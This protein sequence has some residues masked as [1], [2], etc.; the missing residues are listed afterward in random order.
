MPYSIQTKDGIMLDNI[1]DDV[2]PDSDELKKRVAQIRAQRLPDSV[3]PAPIDPQATDVVTPPAGKRRVK[4]LIDLPGQILSKL[5]KDVEEM[6]SR[7][8]ENLTP[9][10]RAN[11]TAMAFPQKFAESLG[12]YAGQAPGVV[13]R[14]APAIMGQR[15][16]EATRIPGASRLGGAAGGLGGELVA[17]MMEGQAPR[18]GTLARAA[19]LGATQ[20]RSLVGAGPNAVATAAALNVANTVGSGAVES[21]INE[22]ELPE[23]MKEQAT[24]ALLA[25]GG[26]RLLDAGAAARAARIRQ[27]SEA[28]VLEGMRGLKEAGVPVSTV[29]KVLPTKVEEAVNKLGRKFIGVPEDFVL[30]P[31]NV[32][33]YIKSLYGVYDEIGKAVPG[34]QKIVSDLKSAR[35]EA[36][37]AWKQYSSSERS[38]AP[39]AAKLEKARGLDAAAEQLESELEKQAVL[40]GQDKLLNRFRENRV[41]IAKAHT[42]DRAL[43]PNRGVVDAREFYRLRERGF[44]ITD[45]GNTIADVYG[46][47]QLD[48][49][50]RLLIANEK[51][52]MLRSIGRGL[53]QTGVGQAL[54]MMPRSYV[55]R[56]DVAAEIARLSLMQQASSVPQAPGITDFLPQFKKPSILDFSR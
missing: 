14:V 18:P 48:N 24:M 19:W 46:L 53:Q 30:T 26:Q 51:L 15:L 39:D 40:A 27:A 6:K 21:L 9:V 29:G 38:G 11:L 42:L 47:R 22:G 17:S 34:G 3:A 33:K 2:K 35:S 36:R 44:I 41:R 52:N 45:E 55:Q 49:E 20:P 54:T 13:M 23:N 4:D 12:F 7:G 43:D 16:G 25:T 28:P 8:W 1:P 50:N 32:D 31:Q 37:I 5:S 10:E 56:P